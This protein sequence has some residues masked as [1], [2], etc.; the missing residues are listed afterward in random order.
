M[1]RAGAS[2]AAATASAYIRTC[3]VYS[4]LAYTDA[5]REAATMF[6]EQAT[7][8]L[9]GSVARLVV[10]YDEL[11]AIGDVSCDPTAY[12]RGQQLLN[13]RTGAVRA[14]AP[15]SVPRPGS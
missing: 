10:I 11:I 13:E 12:H 2:V 9:D 14:V 8:M 6:T 1:A 15:M 5:V 3:E 7:A 4:L